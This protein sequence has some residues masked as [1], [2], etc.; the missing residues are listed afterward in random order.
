M[1]TDPKCTW[2]SARHAERYVCDPVLDLL[3]ALIKRG[4]ALTLPVEEFDA[5]EHKPL[6]ESDLILL[7]LKVEGG[8]CEIG[9]IPRAVLQFH[10]L[11]TTGPTPKWTLVSADLQ[12]YADLIQR[13]SG[14]AMRALREQEKR[15][16]P[17]RN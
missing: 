7:Q 1:T 3:R 11:S 5:L 15:K 14:V 16:W 12:P 4:Q 10:G 8:T 13:M 17:G 2:C 6:Q 9:G